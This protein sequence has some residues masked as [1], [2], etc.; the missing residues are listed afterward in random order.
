MD[1]LTMVKDLGLDDPETLVA[2]ETFRP[3][4]YLVY[5]D[6]ALDDPMP[7][8]KWCRYSLTVIGSTLCPADRQNGI[9]PDMVV[10]I[11]PNTQCSSDTRQPIHPL[12]DF[13][14]PN[15]FHWI[16]ANTYVRMRRHSAPFVDDSRAI[17]LDS[18]QDY[19]ALWTFRQDYERMKTLP[20][21]HDSDDSS[22]I[23]SSS[24]EESSAV[25]SWA[26]QDP[27][28]REACSSVEFS[29]WQRWRDAMA[30]ADVQERPRKPSLPGDTTSGSDTAS[31]A[32]VEDALGPPEISYPANASRWNVDPTIP[33]YPLVDFWFE[34][35]EHLTA[36]SIPSPVE[37]FDEEKKINAMIRDAFARRE[38]AME[39]A[40]L[41]AVPA[42]C[43][44]AEPSHASLSAN[45]GRPQGQ[46]QP[47]STTALVRKTSDIS[48]L[49]DTMV[50]V[51]PARR[52][53][54][55]PTEVLCTIG[56]MTRRV[57]WHV[58]RV[59]CFYPRVEDTISQ[60]SR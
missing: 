35:E 28:V 23:A 40:P 60:L 55:Q 39:H 9:L 7:Y 13:P 30:G 31:T 43:E 32:V 47:A 54:F 48:S 6:T 17:R 37:W 19:A 29:E 10:P 8:S 34:L 18:D 53:R 25:P 4:K 11:F 27:I 24:E 46:V 15:C 45:F 12:R 14:F 51:E 42:L 16:N 52:S 26:L 5:V 2:I 3:K 59:S 21:N 44:R 49:G 22:S 36:E 41:T 56:T 33:L 57:F 50:N 58:G 38:F 1:P 20:P